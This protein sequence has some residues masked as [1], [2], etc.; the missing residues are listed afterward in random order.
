MNWGVI[1]GMYGDTRLVK[2]W[3]TN[4]CG[5]LGLWSYSGYIKCERAHGHLHIFPTIRR[6]G[7]LSDIS[8][9]DDNSITCKH[10]S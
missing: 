10:I 7:L 3:D 4:Q 9:S 5:I 6:H 1:E 8:D 2:H